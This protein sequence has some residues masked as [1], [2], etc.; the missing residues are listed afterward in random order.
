MQEDITRLKGEVHFED[1][2]SHD[3][4]EKQYVSVM[5]GATPDVDNVRFFEGIN[6]A[7]V[8]VT[9][10]LNGSQGQRIYIRGDGQM[11]IVNGTLIFTNTGANKL[12]AA[13]IVYKFTYFEVP[14]PPFSHAWIED[15]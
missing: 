8:N 10:F 7:P 11:T 2:T 5:R 9:D 15:E 14:G 13:N 6:T 12:L 1:M 4:L 3:V